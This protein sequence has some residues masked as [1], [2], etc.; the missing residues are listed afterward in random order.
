M[1][2][3]SVGHSTSVPQSGA[4]FSGHTFKS[5][6]QAQV[7]YTECYVPWLLWPLL[8]WNQMEINLYIGVH[9][10]AL[11]GCGYCCGFSKKLLETSFISDSAKVW[12]TSSSRE[13]ER[14]TNHNPQFPSLG[15]TRAEKA[16]KL[17]WVQAWEG[18]EESCL[19]FGFISHYPS[20]ICLVIKWK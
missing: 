16:E 5:H 7:F 12:G 18:L 9:S 11:K 8:T 1:V 10:E 15:S 20:L 13:N 6:A 4:H 14:W 17:E 19:K 2:L 3:L